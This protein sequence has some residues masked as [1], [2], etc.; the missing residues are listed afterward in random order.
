[1]SVEILK[2]LTHQLRLFGIH[3]SF[4]R[5]AQESINEQLHPLEFLRLILEDE[6]IARKDRISKALSTRARF[7]F[8]A[9]LEDWDFSFER[10]LSRAKLKELSLLSFFH[11]KENLL[12]LGKTGEGKTQLSIS[13]GKRV[14]QEGYKSLFL[15]SSFFFEEVAAHKAAGKYLSYLKTLIKQDLIILDDF[16]L[17]N[18]THEEATSLMDLIEERYQKGVLILSS[19]VNPE[20]W[21]KLFED[22]VIGE[23][24]VDRL[25]HPSQRIILKGGSYRERRQKNLSEKQI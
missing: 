14:C 11:K 21:L 22:P 7:R 5:R 6:Q 12:I 17:R 10:G 23:A 25:V 15:P 24:I 13:L 20:G 3:A 1:M 8:Q 2:N 18:Y 4:E 9:T 16:G 19:Q